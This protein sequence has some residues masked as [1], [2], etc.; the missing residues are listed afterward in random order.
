[1]ERLHLRF[2]MLRAQSLLSYHS[3]AQL[4]LVVVQLGKLRASDFHEE[5]FAL[6]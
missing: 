2:L 4:S 1:M 3:Y 5:P 6:R